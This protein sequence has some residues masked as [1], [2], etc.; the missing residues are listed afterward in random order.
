M[1]AAVAARAQRVPAWIRAIV[2]GP[3]LLLSIALT[4][5]FMVTDSGPWAWISDAQAGVMSGTYDMKLS[6]LCTWL[7]M[8]LVL[9]APAGVLVQLIAFAFPPT[10]ASR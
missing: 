4:I 8:I 10:D 5:F 9:V 2:L 6:F 3:P 1:F 7:G